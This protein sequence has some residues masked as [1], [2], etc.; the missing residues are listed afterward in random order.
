MDETKT[1][2]WGIFLYFASLI[3]ILREVYVEPVDSIEFFHERW[4]SADTKMGM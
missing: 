3:S 4:P 1:A 2:K